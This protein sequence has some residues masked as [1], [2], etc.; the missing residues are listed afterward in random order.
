MSLSLLGLIPELDIQG[1]ILLARVIYPSLYLGTPSGAY[2]FLDCYTQ[3]IVVNMLSSIVI[4]VRSGGMRLYR[5]IFVIYAYDRIMHDNAATGHR[6]N[7]A[8]NN[9]NA[10]TTSISL[11]QC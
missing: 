7:P 2:R 6:F 4:M 10:R 9:R 1:A 11:Y 8:L 3:S 5:A